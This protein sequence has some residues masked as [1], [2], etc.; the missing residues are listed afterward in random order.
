L[1]IWIMCE[2]SVDFIVL[3]PRHHEQFQIVLQLRGRAERVMRQTI[4]RRAQVST[5]VM[6]MV[7]TE[8]KLPSSSQLPVM[9]MKFVSIVRYGVRT[10]DHGY[11]GYVAA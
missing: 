9:R 8:N 5:Y 1:I 3:G 4:D 2:K 7:E 11:I 10:C 6:L